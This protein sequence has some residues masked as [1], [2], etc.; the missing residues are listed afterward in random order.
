[1]RQFS[2][3]TKI[4]KDKDPIKETDQNEKK[5]KVFFQTERVM[6][7]SKLKNISNEK[8]PD[9]PF[10]AAVLLSGYGKQFNLFEAV[11]LLIQLEKYDA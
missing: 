10:R 9:K 2:T 6:P 11:S 1:M 3:N 4:E 8:I 7:S 5:L